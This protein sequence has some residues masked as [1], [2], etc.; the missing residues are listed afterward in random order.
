MEL[1]TK[2]INVNRALRN[3]PN[4]THVVF[5]LTSSLLPEVEMYSLQTFLAHFHIADVERLNWTGHRI[6]MSRQTQSNTSQFIVFDAG[7]DGDSIC[8]NTRVKSFEM[9]GSNLLS[10]RLR[11][12][13]MPHQVSS[14]TLKKNEVI[15]F[16]S[17]IQNKRPT[18]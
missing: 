12:Y 3:A 13:G 1:K 4:P 11:G 5:S 9:M 7:I 16:K 6:Y 15:K 14:R 10:K 18:T 2:L 8:E 17:N